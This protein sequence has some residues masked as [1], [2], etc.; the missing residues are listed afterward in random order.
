VQGNHP[1]WWVESGFGLSSRPSSNQRACA[2]SCSKITISS[3]GA[4]SRASWAAWI[5]SG[6][7]HLAG[8][9]DAVR[10][11]LFEHTVEPGL[12][13]SFGLID[14]ARRVPE[15]IRLDRRDYYPQVDLAVVALF[16][17]VRADLAQRLRSERVIGDYRRQSV[18]H[19]SSTRI[20]VH[21]RRLP[22]PRPG[23]NERVRHFLNMGGDQ[24]GFQ[25]KGG[26]KNGPS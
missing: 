19:R 7:P 1:K 17:S 4:F 9:L 5:G 8:G 20:W 3:V 22:L 16:V 21:D 18:C 25:P 11:E 15:G 14:V 6:S 10:A 12:G 13:F 24:R 23:E 2:C 26:R